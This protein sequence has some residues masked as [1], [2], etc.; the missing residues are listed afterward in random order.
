METP[1]SISSIWINDHL[2]Q[3]DLL[4]L[5]VNSPWQDFP[6]VVATGKTI[7]ELTEKATL[8]EFP[9]YCSCAIYNYD[10]EELWNAKLPSTL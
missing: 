8:Y 5:V 3:P 1:I 10:R 7:D 9:I 4:A 6:E 2:M